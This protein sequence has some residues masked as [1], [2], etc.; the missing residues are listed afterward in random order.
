[1]SIIPALVVSAA[2]SCGS[3]TVDVQEVINA[4]QNNHQIQTATSQDADKIIDVLKNL[5]V[6]F[7]TSE[8]NVKNLLERLLG[9]TISQ[10]ATPAPTKAPEAT[11]APTPAPTKAPEVTKAP[12][13]APTKAP[14]VTKAP[15]PA[16]TKAPQVTKAPTPAPTK[17]PQVTAA[18][19]S[20]YV[21]QVVSLVNEQRAANGLSA[22]TLD[23]TLTA[24]AQKRAVETATSF[25]H[26]RPDGSK[27]STVL[28][29]YG[30]N[31]RYSGENI[32]Y[33]Q[34]TPQE[35]VTAWM[36]SPGHRANILSSNYGKIGVGCYKSGSTYYWSQLFTN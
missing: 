3:A 31:Y 4:V 28:S 1:M 24:A 30:I 23:Q 29:E 33:G 13:P 20:D 14:Q 5:G 21:R 36:N 15:T 6:K 22:L 32:A 27:F 2:L 8:S 17:A 10:Q 35:V 9:G 12:T 25:S 18:P 16:P 7:S 34:K 19:S 26:T 11:K